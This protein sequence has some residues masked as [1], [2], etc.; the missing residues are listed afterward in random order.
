M[1]DADRAG[2]A[3]ACAAIYAPYVTGSP[4]SFEERPPTAAEMAERIAAAYAW[5]IAENG[6]QAIG[7]AYGNQHRERA[8]YRWAAD[9]T[10]YIDSA[11]HRAGVGRALY[12][13]LF[14]RLRAAGLWTVCAGVTQPNDA[15]DGLH[16]AMG[17]TSVG[18]YRR[19][20]WKEGVW[21]DVRWWQ[22]D[23]RPDE[24]GPPDDRP[25]PGT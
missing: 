20:G 22:L 8:A 11:H 7:Y 15:S 13:Q 16:R 24:P 9:V 18:V 21:H 19:I 1:R 17:F 12:T 3:E 6:G 5:L 10:V 25:S 23:L 14:E 2:D 4:I